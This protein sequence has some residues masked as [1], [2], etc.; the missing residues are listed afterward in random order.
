MDSGKQMLIGRTIGELKI[1]VGEL[2][3][4]AFTANQI[5]KWL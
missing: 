2:G 5:A 1:V 4:P 3:M